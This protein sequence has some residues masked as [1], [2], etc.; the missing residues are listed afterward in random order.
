LAAYPHIK[1]PEEITI[2]EIANALAAFIAV[3]W[4]SIDSRFDRYLAGDTGVLTAQEHRGM[5]LFYGKAGCADCHSG[6]LMTD[7]KF[8]ALGLPAF[9]PGRTR[10]FDPYAR[11]V[12]RMGESN[13]LRDAYAFRTPML[14]NV[15]LTA[16]YG[17]NGAY[18]TLEGIIRHHLDPAVA[19]AAWRPG[20]AQLPSV[21]WLAETD[22]IV[23]SD[24]IELER[25]ARAVQMSPMSLEDGEIAALVAFLEALTGESIDTPPF[26]VPDWFRP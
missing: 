19:R 20:L 22:F 13:R 11:D 3:E 21:P 18:P 12:G 7:Q 9:G 6:P 8:H 10:A 14:R 24:A 4:Q 17:H 15:A 26:G 2:A 23:H 25:Q 5:T 1:A 16:P